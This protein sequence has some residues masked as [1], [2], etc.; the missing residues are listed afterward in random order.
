MLSRSME[1]DTILRRAS[2]SR[3]MHHAEAPDIAAGQISR[4]GVGGSRLHIRSKLDHSKGSYK[5]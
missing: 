5:Y 4:V 3:F 1:L 2:S